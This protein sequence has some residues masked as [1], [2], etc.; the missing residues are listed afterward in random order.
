MFE[1][2]NWFE[3]LDEPMREMVTLGFFLLEREEMVGET[4]TDYSFIVFPVAKAYEGFLKKFLFDLNLI[5]KDQL[6]G[7]SFRIGRSLNPNL[8]EEMRDDEWVFER[9]KALCQSEGIEKESLP[10]RLW[11]AWGLGRNSIFH[12]F[13]GEE[14]LVS[15]QIAKE[16]LNML[17]DL[18]KEV[19]ECSGGI[20]SRLKNK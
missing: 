20:R 16:R 3:Y 9:M 19:I 6:M 11:E 13:I 2:H 18:M 15:L 1:G 4:L 17:V 12:Y 7:K 10:E 8:P 14:Q 5:N